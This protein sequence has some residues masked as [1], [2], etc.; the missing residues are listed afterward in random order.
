MSFIVTEW[1]LP[2]SVINIF[3]LQSISDIYGNEAC[4]VVVG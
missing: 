4:F 2:T 3:N 1:I